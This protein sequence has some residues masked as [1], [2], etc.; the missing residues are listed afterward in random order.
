MAEGAIAI[1][2]VRVG[3]PSIVQAEDEMKVQVIYDYRQGIRC[4]GL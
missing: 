4:E 2:G 3:M 1:A